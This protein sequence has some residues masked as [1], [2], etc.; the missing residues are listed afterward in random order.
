MAKEFSQ[1]GVDVNRYGAWWETASHLKNV[2]QY[3]QAW[4]VFFEMYPNPTKMQI[5]NE[6]IRLSIVRFLKTF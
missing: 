5:Y 2:N 3:N 6:V 1:A 4:K